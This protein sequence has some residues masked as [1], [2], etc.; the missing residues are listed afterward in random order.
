[1]AGAFEIA[2][3]QLIPHHGVTGL[4]LA[5]HLQFSACVSNSRYVEY[6]LD[7]PYRT[8]EHYQQLGGII[9]DPQHIDAEGYLPVP[10]EPGLGVAIDEEAI[11]RYE[12]AI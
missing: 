2:G 6:I 9:R 11:A 3:R 7:P 12:V 5:A 1:M 10:T 8:V 4:G